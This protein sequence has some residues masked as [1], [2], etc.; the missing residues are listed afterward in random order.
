V[1]TNQHQPSHVQAHQLGQHLVHAVARSV[2]AVAAV[3]A[4]CHRAQR[5]MGEL[6]IQ[7]DRYALEADLA[8]GTY[9]EFLFRSPGT[10]WREP[11]ARERANA[12]GPCRR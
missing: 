6:R 8:P 11:S 1:N 4:E 10:V 12:A 7:P 3:V 5:V 2:K 9:A